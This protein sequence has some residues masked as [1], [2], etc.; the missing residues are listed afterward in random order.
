[1]SIYTDINEALATVHM[2]TGK[3]ATKIYLGKNEMKR[4]R[5]WAYENQHAGGPKTA[6]KEGAHRAEVLG[7]LVYEVNDDIHLVAV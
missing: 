5:Q 6:K 7:C 4:L 1:M 2:S 3:K